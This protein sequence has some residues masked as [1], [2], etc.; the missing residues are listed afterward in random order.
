M[1]ELLQDSAAALAAYLE[2]YL[3]PLADDWWSRYVLPSL[4]FHQ[5]RIAEEGGSGSLRDLDLAGLLRVTDRNWR[6]LTSRSPLEDDARSW[7]K[8]LQAI[9]NR[10]AHLPAG[11]L[12]DAEQY[13]DADTLYR[14]LE[15][16]V[17]DQ[18]LRDRVEKEREAARDRMP[19]REVKPAEPLSDPSR[20]AETGPP[21]DGHYR[22]GQLVALPT[23]PAT[24]LP[25]LE[26]RT[27]GEEPVYVVLRENRRQE[28]FERQLRLFQEIEPARTPLSADECRALLTS[29]HIRSPHISGLF[30]LR[31]GDVQFVP[32]QYRPVLRLLRADR[33]RLL[34]ADE[35][36]VGKTI[37]AGLILKELQARGGL[38]SILIICPKPLVTERKWA[39]EM[40]RFGEGFLPLDSSTLEYCVE[41]ADLEGEWPSEYSKVILPFSLADRRLLVGQDGHRPRKGLFDLDPPPQFDLVIVDEAHHIRNRN[42]F[43]HQTV[44]FFS[45]HAKAVLFLTATPVQLGSEDLFVLLNALR[46]DLIVDE[47]S[48]EQMAAPNPYLNRAVRV[49]RRRDDGWQEEARDALEL[50]G[51]TD[52]GRRFLRELPEFQSAYDVLAGDEPSDDARVRTIRALEELYT[53]SNL[54]NRTRRRDIGEFTKRKPSTVSVPFTAD[55]QELHDSLLE[56]VASMLEAA[57]GRQNVKFMMTTLRRQAASCIYGLVPLM[58]DML[59]GKIDRLEVLAATD[60]EFDGDWGISSDFIDEVQDVIEGGEQLDP[61]DPKVEAFMRVVYEKQE[62]PKNKILVFSTFRHTLAYL[63]ERMEGGGVRFGVVHG[64]VPDADRRDLRSRF[65]LDRDA[66]N[67]IDVLLSSEVGCEGLDF[68]FCD[69]L[70]NYDL[71]WNPM[72]V[73]QR[74]GRIDR[75]GQESD[76]V[77]IVNLITPGTVDAEIYDRCLWRIGVFHNAVGASEAILGKVTRELRAVAESFELAS[78]ER[79]EKLRQLT[80]N[81]VRLIQEET[82]LEQQQDEL[83][84]LNVPSASWREDLAGHETSWLAPDALDA[85]VS[86]YVRERSGSDTASLRGRGVVKS[87]RLN[88]EARQVLLD[89]FRSI[90][91]RDRDQGRDWESWLQGDEPALGV[92]FDHDASKEDPGLEYITVLHPLV[93]Q[94]AKYVD[95]V[96]AQVTCLSV[97]D[98]G[99]PAGDHHFALYWWKRAGVAERDELVPIALDSRVE[100]GL[101]EAIRTANDPMDRK[102]VP[103]ISKQDDLEARHHRLWVDAQAQHR[104]QHEDLVRQRLRAVEVSHEHRE[105]VVERQIAEAGDPKIRRM[106]E[107]ERTRLQAAFEERRLSLEAAAEACD[108]HASLVMTGLLRVNS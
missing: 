57:H 103:E 15:A 76:A 21:S 88:R 102:L 1:R 98:T 27:G 14:F 54:I 30:S 96:E 99:L 69:L 107:A 34:I 13:R 108:I 37:E 28:F 33:P 97:D 46:P 90:S 2:R 75:F 86:S 85:L 80:D 24:A 73:E 12:P 105:S 35:V 101:I 26:V 25:V 58:E 63:A 22:P 17:A 87:L 19:S 4:S 29:Q 44:R 36:G 89:D 84:G 8:E 61:A 66:P 3:S 67:A 16:I 65:A 55:Q 100:S 72:R 7:V 53:F 39:K 6:S 5:R 94:A 60:E 77:A 51:N 10:W 64:D 62:L 95:R 11:G 49:S 45:D 41:E 79:E 43:L 82:N 74:I 48:F 106:R 81:A 71:P 31:V 38:K 91:G 92:T 42:T 47:A 18:E 9:R 56:L 52:W 20:V 40:K 83:F 78:D 68:Q 70:V 93:R 23:D 32:Y 50:A 59:L 104:D